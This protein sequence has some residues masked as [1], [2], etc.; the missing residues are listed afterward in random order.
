MVDFLYEYEITIT[1]NCCTDK[2]ADLKK[3]DLQDLV[4][5]FEKKFDGSLNEFKIEIE[6]TKE[7]C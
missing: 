1:I 7:E 6:S 2:K 5:E 3:S 4:K